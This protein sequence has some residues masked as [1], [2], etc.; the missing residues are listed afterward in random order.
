MKTHPI[1][2]YT[3]IILIFLVGLFTI[4]RQPVT[5][6]GIYHYHYNNIGL[7][8]ISI[9]EY[10][11]LPL[12]E[13]KENSNSEITSSF[14]SPAF[15]YRL[16]NVRLSGEAGSLKENIPLTINRLDTS[17][18]AP[19]NPGMVNV[20]GE[21]GAYRMLPH[22][23]RFNHPIDIILPYDTALLPAGYT[24]ADIMTYYYDE[25]Y[26]RWIAIERDSIDEDRSLII[27]RVDHFTDFINAVIKTPEMPETQGYAP[28][29]MTDIKA[30]DPLAGLHLMQPPSANNNGTATIQYPIEIPAG[31]QGMQPSLALNYNS[32]GGNGWLGIGWD[33]SLPSINVETR[34]GVPRYYKDKESELY[35]FNGEQLLNKDENGRHLPMPHRTNS[36]RARRS[37]DLRFYPRVDESFDMIVRHGNNPADYW[38]SVTDRNGVTHY[39]G[40]DKQSDKVDPQSVLCDAHGNIANWALT[41]SVDL[42][43]NTVRYY[44]DLVH[45]AGLIDEKNGIKGKQLYLS[46][47]NYT[48]DRR[49][50]GIFDILFEIKDTTVRKDVIISG[51]YGFKQVT[52]HLLCNIQ[53]QQRKQTKQAYLFVTEN[54]P[55]SLY[56]TRLTDVVKITHSGIKEY[57]IPDIESMMGQLNATRTHFDYFDRPDN[58][59]PSDPIKVTG[60]N[61]YGV[62]SDF[63]TAGFQEGHSTAL[64]STK[65][66]SWNAG[67]SAALGVGVNV[68][69]STVSAGGNFDYSR[70]GSEGMLTLIDLDG[71]GL[72]DKV[73]KLGDKVYYCKHI[74]QAGGQFKFADSV[75]L[76]GITD[77]LSESSSTTT[78]GLQASAGVSLSGSWPTV[79]STTNVY[80]ADVNVDGLPD[81]I[82]D[83]GVLFNTLR[84][85]I[86]H[87]IPFS[88]LK[89]ETANPEYPDYIT[90]SGSSPCGGIIFDGEVSDSIICRTELIL[91][92]AYANPYMGTTYEEIIAILNEE[93]RDKKDFVYK[94]YPDDKMVYIYKKFRRCDPEPLDPDMDVVKVWAAPMDG[95]IQIVSSLK[96]MQDES[97]SR[98]QSK[99]ANG[100]RYTIQLNRDNT[101]G[102]DLRDSVRF[103]R[104]TS[105]RELYTE[106]VGEN[107]YTEKKYETI[108]SVKQGDLLFF[109]L[110]SG[111]DRS[112]DQVDWKQEIEY[113]SMSGNLTDIYG[114]PA[115]KYHSREDFILSG[116]DYFQAPESGQIVIEGEISSTEIAQPAVLYIY[117]NGAQVD[118]YSIMPHNQIQVNYSDHVNQYDS[119]QFVLTTG[120]SNGNTTWSNITFTPKITFT[121]TN[122]LSSTGAWSP[123]TFEYYPSVQREVYKP[124]FDLNQNS[125]QTDYN[126]AILYAH[127][128]KLF[129]ELYRGWGQFVYNNNAGNASRLT[130]PIDVEQ[131]R[132]SSAFINSYATDTTGIYADPDCGDSTRQAVS[133]GFEAENMYNP[134]SVDTRW[135][136]MYPDNKNKAWVGYG[137]INYI[138]GSTMSNMR[139]IESY[140]APETEDIPEYDHPVPQASAGNPVV[141]TVRKQ[142]ESTMKNYSR[143]AGIP[144]SPIT[145]GGSTSNGSNKILSDYMDLNGDRYPDVLSDGGVQY[146]M[147]WGGIGTYRELPSSAAGISE[148][149][150]TS[151]GRTFGASYS[152]PSRT[153]GNNPKNAKISFDGQGSVS[154]NIGNGKDE[155]EY[156]WM[157][158]NGDGLPDKVD[159]EGRV[160]LNIGYDFLPF[161][162]WNHAYVRE[163]SSE[164]SGVSIGPGSVNIAQLSIGG[165]MGVNQSEN[166]TEAVLMDFNGDGLPDRIKCL[167]SSIQVSYNLGNGTWSSPETIT[168][169]RNV[170][171]G[172]SF[173]ESANAAVTAGFTLFGI[174]KFTVS[175]QGAPYNRSFNKDREQLVDIDGDGYLDYVTSKT[176]NEMTVYYNQTGKTNLLKKVT[177]F[178]GSAITLDYDMP[179]GSYEKPQRSWH[180]AKAEYHDPYSPAGGARNLTTFEYSDPHYDRYERI[181]YGY[182]RITSKQH[183]TENRDS[184]YRYTVENYHNRNFV[185]R[186]KKSSEILYDGQGRKQI[187]T[188]YDIMLADMN[189][190]ELIGDENCPSE[191]F[192]VLESE[193]RHYY[194]GAA[195]PQIT[196]RKSF[197]YDQYRNVVLYINYGDIN[198]PDDDFKAEIVYETGL[199]HN[200]ISLQKSMTVYGNSHPTNPGSILRKRSAIYNEEGKVMEIQ[201]H[202]DD[203]SLSIYNYEYD[204]YGNVNLMKMPENLNRQRMEYRY[205]YDTSVHTYPE[206]ITNSLGYTSSAEYD[207][208]WGKPLLT[209]DINRNE[210]W[211]AY[212]NLGRLVSVTS[213]YE[214]LSLV[215][216]TLKME[217]HPVNFSKWDI[218]E[219]G[220]NNFSYAY[221]YHYDPQHPDNPMMTTLLCDNMGRWLQTKKDTEIGGMELS[222]VLGKT[223]YDAFGRTVRQYHPFTES[224]SQRNLYNNYYQSSTATTI[225]YD[226][227][228]REIYMRLPDNAETHMEYGFAQD[229]FNK[230]RFTVKTTDAKRNIVTVY[231][232]YRGLQTTVQ[233]PINTQTRFIYNR[234]GELI[235]ST[236]PDGFETHYGYD[237]LGRCIIRHHPDAGS[238]KYFFDPA[239]NMIEHQTQ[240]LIDN[241]QSVKYEYHYNQLMAVDY[242]ENPVNRVEYIYGND[243]ALDNGA[244]RVIWQSD[245]AG[246]QLFYYGPFGEITKQI[247]TFILM[248]EEQPYSFTTQFNYDAW[249][250][251]QNMTYPDGEYVE[252]AYN[253]GGQ[254]QSVTGELNNQR[255]PY[256]KDIGYNEFEMKVSMEYGNGTAMKYD[257]D[258]LQRLTSLTSLTAHGESMQELKYHYDAVGNIE[259]ISNIAGVLNNGLGGT[260][261][262]QYDYDDLYR[263]KSAN[264]SF[265]GI[266][267]YDL[268]MEYYGNGRIHTKSQRA[269]ILEEQ[270]LRRMDYHNEYAYNNI[271][272]NILSEVNDRNGGNNQHFQWDANGNMTY[273]SDKFSGKERSLYW[274][275]ENR[276]M[277]ALDNQSA[278]YYHYDASGERTY[279]L[280]GEIG[281]M[282]INNRN[283]NYGNL[284]DPTLYV[285]PYLVSNQKYY[286]KHYYA[287][288]ERIAS[289]VG[290]ES[291]FIGIE[292]P[293]SIYGAIYQDAERIREYETAVKENN[294]YIYHGEIDQIKLRRD[295]MMQKCEHIFKQSGI[296]MIDVLTNRLEHLKIPTY[297]EPDVYFYHPDHLGSS[298]W[299]TSH[300]GRAIQYMNYLP[301]G[302][303]WVDQRNSSWSAPYTFS[304]KER[305][306]ETGYSY[307]GARYYNAGLGIWLSVD[308]MASK[309]PSLSAYVYCANN[310][311][312]LKDPDGRDIWTIYEDGTMNRQKDKKIDRVDVVDREGNTIKG[313]EVKSGTIKQYTLSL[314]HI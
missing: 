264:G 308:P 277:A 79:K 74:P 181:E 81:L 275:E 249:N 291:P 283:Y 186:G 260:Y 37:G 125:P 158:M 139:M 225:N 102:Y 44:Y 215:P 250:R 114:K 7:K 116:K 24:P 99:F 60:L 130:D 300:S 244:G 156:S 67:G 104:S 248:G 212:D 164:N 135:V 203:G 289:K 144:L 17:H 112:F 87:F 214:I 93:Y 287:G 206:K 296:E 140:S 223:V 199:Q 12:S 27:S 298:S 245:A 73:Y 292:V 48:G 118:N 294:V 123:Q 108:V 301:F 224:L 66:K 4:E 62:K 6:A 11:L 243:G 121:T 235:K 173:S 19:L 222:L 23:T 5:N 10:P 306:A 145:T 28:T 179:A 76:K 75:E 229:A 189:S 38:W 303:S 175:V 14:V 129:G 310:P 251:I 80:F 107:D 279:K 153:S 160:S 270:V 72:A 252:Y 42:Y 61:S 266:S 201:Q 180:L 233:A 20:T 58:I 302:E 217:Y 253:L 286:T 115:K 210:I 257:Y 92:T 52:A 91:D 166:R 197:K 263:L 33:I 205:E 183:D 69:M 49:N 90:T 152:M 284:H 281:V 167:G 88:T 30:A 241:G 9:G 46:R 32:A 219:N 134:L 314:I 97:E 124:Y 51:Q 184:L 234:M 3:L 262:H 177:N 8:P 78:W 237:L 70:S 18:I 21:Y 150:T 238:D 25:N 39:Y 282:R 43:G 128:E 56:K 137:N 256:V 59:Y 65:G 122:F 295:R 208:Y 267:N 68:C 50:E 221:T 218:F 45:H 231:K 105:I 258:N 304:G 195:T 131:L 120:L 265:N 31:R 63:L 191:V 47:I 36:W 220:N 230:K 261:Q 168:G 276:L 228:D 213:P 95:T 127:Y 313:T 293:L 232:D 96:L 268:S 77:F 85:G 143:T 299:I 136:E 151:D 57:C 64:G 119:I 34:W 86:P 83:Y 273:H 194:E 13:N 193:I 111:G 89:Q 109:R 138:K 185:K 285:S 297:I 182:A 278:G 259:N 26:N 106:T 100:I 211:Y 170:S 113:Q 94:F 53:I 247:R 41:E 209:R 226:I 274:D 198:D 176:E 240:N 174:L 155:T 171:Y 117:K 15:D 82:T 272:P 288:S 187:E 196:T 149:A 157:D 165:G 207:Y 154:G 200:L 227:Q 84:N 311:L 163:G 2:V 305:D 202:N 236:D 54:T 16:G 35:L 309:Y 239:G 280:A 216:Y 307:F 1:L 22:G 271:Q 159:N 242:P 148:S 255:Y 110:Q 98:R 312:I 169:V 178:T 254:L 29:T 162:K 190:G 142:N 290:G 146:T 132:F 141:K 71:D 147:P 40:K 126:R 101:P 188:L 161:E 246:N 133:A 55:Q 269:D 172:T 103:L 192:P 204:G